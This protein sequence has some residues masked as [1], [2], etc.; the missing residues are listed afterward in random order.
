MNIK[1]ILIFVVC[2][3]VGAAIIV[4]CNIGG[5]NNPS[6]ALITPIPNSSSVPL[7]T[8]IQLQFSEPVSGVYA[9]P[10]TE[11]PT[12]RSCHCNSIPIHQ[13]ISISTF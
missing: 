1:N 12:K 7:N 13:S 9:I 5:T 11:I 6:V 8:S 4:S 10:S 3:I 2:G